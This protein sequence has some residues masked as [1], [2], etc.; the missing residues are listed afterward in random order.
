MQ[1]ISIFCLFLCCT[2]VKA[3]DG[4]NSTMHQELEMVMKKGD[5][6]A[7]IVQRIKKDFPEKFDKIKSTSYSLT[8]LVNQERVINT[9]NVIMG[10]RQSDIEQGKHKDRLGEFADLLLEPQFIVNIYDIFKFEKQ[11]Q[12]P[13]W[14]SPWESWDEWENVMAPNLGSLVR[15]DGVDCLTDEMLSIEYFMAFLNR[16]K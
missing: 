8:F 12:R 10:E 15:Q 13:P 16:A 14:L 1:K 5:V 4:A 3:V 2:T 7:D 9:F 6:H 11:N